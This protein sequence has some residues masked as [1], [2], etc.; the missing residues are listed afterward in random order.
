M[1][2]FVSTAIPYVNA[3]PHIGHALE[4]VQADAYVRAKRL[5][6]EDVFFLTGTDDNAIKNVQAAEAAGV[7]IKEY[8]AE[9]AQHFIDLDTRLD[10]AYDDFI[11]T[12]VDY[13]HKAGVEKLWRATK[14]EDLYKKS[15]RG[16]YCVGC[17]EF[18]TEKD[19]I[20][21]EC[22]EHPGKP[23]EE[24]EEENYFFRLS[25]YQDRLLALIEN[26]TIRI[27]PEGRKNEITSFIKGGLEDFSV[28]RSAARAKGWG[29]PVPGDPEQYLY[30]WYD[31][32]ANYIT[33]LGY[34]EDAEA[35]QKYWVT[36][37]EK[38]H[39]I[40]KGINR[41]HTVYWPAMLLSAGVPLPTTV[42][43]HGYTTSG[44]AKMSK[45][46]GNVIDANDLIDR[47]GTDAVR[48]MLLRHGNPTEDIDITLERC[49]EWYTAHLTNGLGN[50]V[51]RVMKLAETHLPEPV[52]RPEASPFPQ[53][54]WDALDAFRFNEAMD[55]V[56]AKI[57][58][59]DERITSEKPF[60]V[61]KEDEEKGRAMIAE[62]ATEIYQIGRL[63]NPFMPATSE[64]IKAAVLANRKPDNIFPRLS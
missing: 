30:V 21:G 36:A 48:Y 6:G 52:A 2:R 53:E 45:S 34:A 26:D 42:F 47:Y 56:W 4:Y 29:I 61:V 39:M 23:L 10:V 22:P 40:G 3:K 44:G 31:A 60:A 35:Y 12:S 19:L 41:F 37:E 16:F 28:S 8:I 5:A 55:M 11:R 25:A 14:P 46:V 7:P 27:I 33:A 15:Y 13:R 32:L 20:N 9:N 58:A 38:V 49:D 17:E 51:A 1:A 43:V 54:Y 62:L 57:G 50:L 64:A 18:K 59:L 63:L 24:V